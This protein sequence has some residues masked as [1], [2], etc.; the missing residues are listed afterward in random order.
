MSGSAREILAVPRMLRLLDITADGRVLVASDELR[1]EIRGIDPATGKDRKGLEWFDGSGLSDISPDG[2]TILF[3]EWGGPAGE[4]YLVAYRKLDGSAPTGLGEGTDPKFSPDGTT[5]AA[6]VLTRPPKLALHPIGTGE[7]KRL[8]L[9]EIVA[10]THVAWFP[11]GTHV[12]LQ[13]ATAGEAL[14]TYEMDLAGG[15]PVAV[16]PVGFL[17]FAVANDGRRN[18]SI[19]C[20]LT[21]HC[22]VL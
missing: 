14:R 3:S 13:A 9:G 7:S 8:G 6:P 11:N 15:K 4:L 12:L 16:G 18:E 21:F 17:G 22:A 10:V 20:S 5:A 2:K 1:S 19:L